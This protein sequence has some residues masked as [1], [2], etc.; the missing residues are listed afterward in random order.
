M[1]STLPVYLM[2]VDPQV[3]SASFNASLAAYK[4]SGL[5]MEVSDIAGNL[6]RKFVPQAVRS[7]GIG[8]TFG[9][10][11]MTENRIEYSWSF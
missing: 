10:R 3:K 7:L 1:I 8:F 11:L 4:Q 2:S 9:Y 5:E 6:E